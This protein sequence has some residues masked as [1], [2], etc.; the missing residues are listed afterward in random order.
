MGFRC[1]ECGSHMFGSSGAGTDSLTRHCH[2]NEKW[3]CKFS[4]PATDDHKYFHETPDPAYA[5]SS[6]PVPDISPAKYQSVPFSCI[7]PG[8][9]FFLSGHLVVML[10]DCRAVSLSTGQE[11][12]IEPER[13]CNVMKSSTAIEQIAQDLKRSESDLNELREEARR[14]REERL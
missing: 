12:K 10:A 13:S 14:L 4:F 1:P 8:T 11:L 5:S 9:V 7:G 2:G 6:K 3:I